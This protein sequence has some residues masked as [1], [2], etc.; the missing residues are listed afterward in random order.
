F[1][2]F[3]DEPAGA[4][5]FFDAFP[6]AGARM[7]GPYNMPRQ[8][9]PGAY[10]P[11]PGAAPEAARAAAAEAIPPADAELSRL[12]EINL[13]RERM[14]AA[15][16]KEDFEQAMQLREEIKKMEGQRL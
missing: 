13:L 8:Y 10:M 1:D 2:G 11:G 4:A 12:R 3:F 16:S 14:R 15:A 6:A 9:M 5:G 7:P